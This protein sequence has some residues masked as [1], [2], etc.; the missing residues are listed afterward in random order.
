M[1]NI[2]VLVVLVVFFGGFGFSVSRMET[3]RANGADALIPLAPVDP[4]AI[5]MGDYME[6]EFAV[7]EDIMRALREK[8]AKALLPQS[9][10]AFLAETSLKDRRGKDVPNPQNT[11]PAFA[12]SRLDD[13]SP[14][15][16]GEMPLAF[17]VRGRRVLTASSAFYF[18]EGDASAYEQARFGRMKLDG[19]GK[20]L[21][22]TLCDGDGRDIVPPR[23][24]AAH[25][26]PE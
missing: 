26:A 8:Y 2:L 23:N 19:K 16:P 13:G 12:F 3:L 5:L 18:Q 15:A 14:V 6:L 22:I 20:T 1:R 24:P 10:V 11:V 9:G 7:N 4:R 21:L 17:K 25:I